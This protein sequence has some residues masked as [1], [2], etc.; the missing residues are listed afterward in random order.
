M[1]VTQVVIVDDLISETMMTYTPFQ[2]VTA[3]MLLPFF[4]YS[5]NHGQ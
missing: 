5:F 2:M 3:A 4:Y 1:G